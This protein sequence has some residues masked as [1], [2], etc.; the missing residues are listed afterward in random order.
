MNQRL[1]PISLMQR[2][3]NLGGHF[4]ALTVR[5]GDS[6]WPIDP[7]LGVDH[8]WVSAP[9]FPAH[10][11][12]G[13]SAV[14][15]VF[16]DSEVG[17]LN[18]DSLGNENRIEPGSL[19]WMAAGRGVVHEEIPDAAPGTLHMLQIFVNLPSD[20]QQDAPF[21]LSLAAS[22]VPV[23]TL[24]NARVRVP[25][26]RFQDQRSPL[27]AP[28]DVTMLD[29]YIKPHSVLEIPVPA[30]ESAFVMPI[31]DDVLVNGQLLTSDALT[32]PAF[33]ATA[34]GHTIA[35]QTLDRGAKV[36]L[37]AGKPLQQDVFWNGPM[38]FASRSALDMAA[39]RFQ[40][41][42]F[43]TLTPTAVNQA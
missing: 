43:G 38:A 28:T 19:H 18:R 17:I 12:A 8:A 6:A 15:Y 40:L 13:F 25:L 11:H 32:L 5:G 27:L 3:M 39:H 35:I 26:G 33:G 16:L 9:T 42:E 10:P 24:D 37:F 23:V 34:T 36:V 1:E 4:H 29:I 2:R 22:E 31:L 41:G 30:G 7:F 21:A 14:S 20:R